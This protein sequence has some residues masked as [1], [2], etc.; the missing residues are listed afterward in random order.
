[1]CPKWGQFD[2]STRSSPVNKEASSIHE[3]QP[4]VATVAAGL[5]LGSNCYQGYSWVVHTWSSCTLLL[6]AWFASLKKN[7][8]VCQYLLNIWSY[9]AICCCIPSL[10]V[11]TVH[12][13]TLFL[14]FLF[15]SGSSWR[16][17]VL[18]QHEELINSSPGYL[19]IRYMYSYMLC[20]LFP[21]ILHS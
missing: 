12:I 1:M 21:C 3:A 5:L 16:W 4:R 19:N 18:L 10:P 17:V 11:P 2:N 13:Y 20:F 7:T 9:L 6:F 15:I 14:V 8:H